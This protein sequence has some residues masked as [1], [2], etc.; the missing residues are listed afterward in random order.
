MKIEEASKNKSR[1]DGGAILRQALAFGT[2]VN[3]LCYKGLPTK[4][5]EAW[6]YVFMIASST[7]QSIESSALRYSDTTQITASTA[8]HQ[9]KATGTCIL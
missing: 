3:M 2:V 6:N 8:S 1:V 5:Y 9:T 7:H 4:Y